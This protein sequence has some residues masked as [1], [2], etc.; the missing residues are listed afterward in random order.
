M[1]NLLETKET[2]MERRLAYA[3]KALRGIEAAHG[4]AIECNADLYVIGIY[5]R[6][7]ARKRARVARLMM[8]SS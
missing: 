6:L 5:W 4:S 8:A 3:L 1:P 2:D 7:L